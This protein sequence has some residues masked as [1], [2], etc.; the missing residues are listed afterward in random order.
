MN[1]P[2]SIQNLAPTWAVADVAKSAVLKGDTPGHPFHGNQWTTGI[3]SRAAKIASDR[4]DGAPNREDVLSMA[5]Y[6]RGEARKAIAARDET[7]YKDVAYN[8]N[9]LA[10]A[11]L[12]AETTWTKVADYGNRNVGR[13]AS[14][15]V[16]QTLDAV[17][18]YGNNDLNA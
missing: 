3:V 16:S 2:F 9:R 4:I 12:D 1:N 7:G 13:D 11:H 15:A 6:H 10:K 14:I 8:L 5:Q 17:N 18:H